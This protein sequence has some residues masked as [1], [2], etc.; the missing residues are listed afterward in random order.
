MTCGKKCVG[1]GVLLLLAAAIGGVWI[2]HSGCIDSSVT[3]P[4]QEKDLTLDEIRSKFQSGDFKQKLE[5]GKQIDK[6][7]PSEKLRVLLTL[8]KEQDPPTRVLAVK[9]L[10]PIDD[11][12][13]RETLERLAKEDP[14]PT[15]RQLASERP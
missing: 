13:A 6:L 10:K 2:F 3:Q 11:P 14:D 8:S 15:V 12:R 7:E 4:Y 5:A 1:Y 9:K